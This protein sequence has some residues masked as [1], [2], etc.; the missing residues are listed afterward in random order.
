MT[1]LRLN[2]NHRR[3]RPGRTRIAPVLLALAGAAAAPAA[4]AAQLAP[5]TGYYLHAAAASESSPFSA[6][7]VLD[8]Q[9]LRLMTRPTWGSARFDIAWETTLSLRSD[10]LALGRGF[11]GAEPA[12]PWLDLQ[13]HL[14]DQRRVEWTHGLDRLS[15]SIQGGQRARL[16]IGRQ[17]ISWATT[18]FFTP[19]DPF[20]PW[21][22]ADPFR[23]YRA[24][25][26]AVRGVLFTGPFSEVDAVIRPAPAPGGRETWTALLRGQ[27]LLA[28]W[29]VSAWGGMVHD[30]PAGAVAGA[31]SLGEWGIRGEGSLR[32]G[33]E[34]TVVRAALGLD[35]LFE[36]MG[37]DFRAV[38]EIQHDGFGAA[39]ASELLDTALSAPAVQG[40]LSVLGREALVANATWQ[41]HPL[42]SVS[43][44]SLVSLRDGS[45]LLSPGLTWSLADELSLRLGAFAGTG[46]GADG[47]ELRSEH[48]ATPLIGFAALSAF[49]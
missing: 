35:R 44:L 41:V 19:A 15:V 46:P 40:E 24:G 17:P 4:S 27:R 7:G 29:E 12:A 43:L 11:E 8:V 3:D 1:L 30:E 23:E 16:T 21:D 22:P 5:V 26:D 18:L 33:D 36:L 25:V 38:V 6:S 47:M 14:V 39:R 32:S 9:R 31:G 20:V 28:G 37:R 10:E 2:V 34:G 48:G 13:G 49:F 45:A 42:A